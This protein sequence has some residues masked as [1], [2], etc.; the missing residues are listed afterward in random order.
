MVL[1]VVLGVV[2]TGV[3]HTLF[4]ASMRVVSAHTASVVAALEPVYG[5]ALALA[6]LREIPGARTWLGGALIVAAALVASRRAR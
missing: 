5:V 3:A 6:L 4:I 2:C 1:L